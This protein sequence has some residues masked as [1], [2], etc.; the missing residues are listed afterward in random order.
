MKVRSLLLYVNI[1]AAIG[2]ATA[3]AVPTQVR[4]FRVNRARPDDAAWLAGFL[5]RE[6]RN[7]GTGITVVLEGRLRL[8]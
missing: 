3:R 4:Q 1:P 2:W 6:G 5:E 7:F 8:L